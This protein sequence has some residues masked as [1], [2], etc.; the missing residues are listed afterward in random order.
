MAIQ[1]GPE[2]CKERFYIAAQRNV[3]GAEKTANQLAG[4]LTDTGA[5]YCFL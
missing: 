4:A 3:I 5:A 2:C 1:S